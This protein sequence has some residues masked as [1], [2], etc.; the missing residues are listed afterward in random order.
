MNENLKAQQEFMVMN[1]RLQV[2]IFLFWKK[3]SYEL[4]FF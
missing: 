1:S 2:G 3:A 4:D